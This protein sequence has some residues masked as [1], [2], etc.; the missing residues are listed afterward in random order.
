MTART[1]MTGDRIHCDL[2]TPNHFLSNRSVVAA[3][4]SP[5]M[6]P[7]EPPPYLSR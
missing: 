2:V 6:F 4:S 3:A 7:V 5:T 1:Q